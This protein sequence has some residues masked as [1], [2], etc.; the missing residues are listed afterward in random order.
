MQALEEWRTALAALP[1]LA[2]FRQMK[3]QREILGY[4]II[5]LFIT[6]LYGVMLA[7]LVEGLG[8]RPF[9][10]NAITFPSVNLLSYFLQSRIAFQ[11]AFCFRAYL[12]FFASCLL[13]YAMTLAVAWIAEQAGL[14]YLTGYL[15][16]TLIVPFLNFMLLKQWVFRGTKN[17]GQTV[18]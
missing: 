15:L 5:G 12:R 8:L 3:I 16:I 6:L 2:R 17:E 13:S 1:A 9:Y 11:R 4:V 10:A 18:G 7:G 14:S